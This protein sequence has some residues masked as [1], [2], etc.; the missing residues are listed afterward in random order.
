MSKESIYYF[1]FDRDCVNPKTGIN[2]QKY[3]V[4]IVG[5]DTKAEAR[6]V[7]CKL[8]CSGFQ[9]HRSIRNFDQNLCPNGCYEKIY[10]PLPNEITIDAEDP[11]FSKKKK[12]K[13]SQSWGELR[14]RMKALEAQQAKVIVSRNKSKLDQILADNR[15]T[16][17]DISRD[18]GI[19]YPVLLS[20]KLGQGKSN[21]YKARTLQNLADYLDVD[22]K[23]II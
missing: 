4:E 14:R 17:K 8:Y 18:T 16:I 19:S 12:P 7:M 21:D 3:W 5:A 20:I 9:Q 6:D 22:V 13:L 10:L 1:T 15:I 23:D 11:F 2:M